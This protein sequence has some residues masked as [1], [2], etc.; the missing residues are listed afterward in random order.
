[1]EEGAKGG[2]STRGLYLVEDLQDLGDVRQL[3][4]GVLYEH[5]FY[6]LQIIMKCSLMLTAPGCVQVFA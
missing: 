2:A 5:S 6:F 3:G 4:Y 1:M